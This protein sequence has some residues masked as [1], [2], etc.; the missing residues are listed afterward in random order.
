MAAATVT[1]IGWELAVAPPLSVATAVTL[2]VPC[3]TPLQVM[4]KG[5]GTVGSDEERARVE[6]NA[7]HGAVCI[8]GRCGDGDIGRSD[9]AR[10]GGDGNCRRLVD[11]RRHCHGDRLG[12][13]RG[14]AV[15]RRDGRQVVRSG[16]D[17]APRVLNGTALLGADELR[18]RVDVD[19]SD[20]P[21][22]SPAVAVMGMVAGEV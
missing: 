5:L 22:T 10:L 8:R 18:A 12:R 3:G 13:R 4:A 11:R 6:I 9:V 20:L 19:A 17:T 2:Y 1:T 14:A 16:G 7:R 21:S 15:V